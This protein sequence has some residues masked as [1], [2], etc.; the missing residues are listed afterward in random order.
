MNDN[1]IL[2]ISKIGIRSVFT[3][4]KYDLEIL[5]E[6]LSRILFIRNYIEEC[7][8]YV[9]E[10]NMGINTGEYLT[11]LKKY[12]LELFLIEC[13]EAMPDEEKNS[14]DFDLEVHQKENAEYFNYIY[15]NLKYPE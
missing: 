11:E 1:N 3:V 13:E 12:A 14:A 9:K 2:T 15:D 5:D 10:T 4:K 6:D 8:I 7:L